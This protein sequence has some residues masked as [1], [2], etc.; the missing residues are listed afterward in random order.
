MATAQLDPAALREFQR[1]FRG[2]LIEPADTGYDEHRKVWNGSI[3]RHPALIARC[4][5]TDDVISAIRFA[6][7]TGLPLAVRGGGHSF[8]GHSV[9]DG[10][11]VADLSQLTDVRVDPQKRT[12]TAQAGT[13]LGQLDA[14]TQ[15]HGLAV[16]AGI[17][18]HTGLAG[19][20]LGGGIGWL[21]RKFGLTIDQLLSVE[22]VTASGEVVRASEN[23]NADL[24]WGIRGGGGN[25]GVVTEFEFN[26]NPLGPEVLAGPIF[27]LIEESP[28]VLRFYRDWIADAPDDLMTIVMHRKAPPLDFVPQELHGK[29][30]VGIV[31]CYAGSIDEGERVLKPL[32]EFGSPVLDLCQ[33][34]PYLE[35]QA[36]LDPSFPHGRWYYMRACDV[37]ELTDEVIDI[38]VEHAMRIRSPLTAFPIWQM[39]GAVSRVPDDATRI[40]EPRR[41]PHVQ[42]D[43]GDRRPGRVRRGA[44]V[45]ARL[46]VGARAAPDGRV[47]ELPD[48]GG[49][50]A[51]ARGLRRGEVRP[52]EGAEAGIRPR[53][54]L[55]LQP[56]HPA[57]LTQRSSAARSSSFFMRERPGMSRSRASS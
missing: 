21:M 44:P 48:G 42:P 22:V 26:L 49:G 32:R 27:W 36:M 46:L 1:G 38:T 28:E 23:E 16:P 14:A 13:L 2:E 39:G 19:L 25:F 40:H 43:R 47:R 35:H 53:Q 18:T 11:V 5:G 20:T 6:Q 55:P 56:E 29:L 50:G 8:P 54:R 12:A 7:H 10:G 37:A 57:G 24:F 34:K 17:V 9:C 52:P 31:S 33:P 51:G 45:G 30:I 41:G 15:A 3:D 4:A